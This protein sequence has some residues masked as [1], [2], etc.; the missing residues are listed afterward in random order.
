MIQFPLFRGVTPK[1]PSSD[2]CILFMAHQLNSN[3]LKAFTTLRNQS[4]DAYDVVMLYDN[5]RED[6]DAKKILDATYFLVSEAM[7]A[8]HYDMLSCDSRG[9]M[10]DGNTTF[11]VLLYFLEHS[12]YNYYWRIEY[13]VRYGG[14]WKD[15]FKAWNDNDADLLTTTLTYHQDRLNWRWWKTMRKPWWT[16][17]K[18]PLI[19]SFLPVCRL[20]QRACK[21][22]HAAYCKGWKGHDE[23]SVP[24]ILNAY[25]QK[26]ED[27]GGDGAFV[28]PDNKNK[29]YTNNPSKA[30]LAPGTLLC[31]PEKPDLIEGND[32]LYHPVK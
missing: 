25:G 3:V 23:V 8:E 30:G 2:S 31:P 7:A 11:P 4:G 16:W 22:L 32:M 10:Y 29:F 20:S 19:R 5:T 9:R 12:Q 26:I 17:R 18:M 27:I 14:N 24:T 15:F 6:F 1:K 21:Q 28:K 13:D